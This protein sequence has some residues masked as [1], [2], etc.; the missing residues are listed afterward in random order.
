MYEWLPAMYA[1]HDVVAR[2][3]TEGADGVPEA[4]QR[5]GQLR[6]FLDLFGSSLDLLRESAEDLRD[7]HA[8][9]DTDARLLPLLANWVGWDLSFGAS[10]PIQRSEIKYAADLYRVTATLPGC[11][12]WVKRVTGWPC[13]VKEFCPNVFF[14][15]DVGTSI[16]QRPG[17]RGSRTVNTADAGL[18]SRIGGPD[19]DLDYSYDTGTTD[20]D[21]YAYNAVGLFIEPPPDEPDSQIA[22]KRDR[23]KRN[24]PLFLPVNIRGVVILRAP[25]VVEPPIDDQFDFRAPIV[26]GGGPQ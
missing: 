15:N 16:L 25:A 1:R 2:P 4:A 19:D 13:R 22:V 18:L 24:L 12:G 11:V 3:R 17:D 6:R 10:V 21:W 5:G 7:L 14:S 20:A 23:L 26:E 9:D 8:V